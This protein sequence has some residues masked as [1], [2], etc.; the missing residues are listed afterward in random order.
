MYAAAVAVVVYLM[1]MVPA[2]DSTVATSLHGELRLFEPPECADLILN[3]LILISNINLTLYRILPAHC[4]SGTAR[5]VLKAREKEALVRV[6]S[7]P[8]QN[9]TLVM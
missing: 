3:T 8:G 6:Y 1:C 2:P 9:L 4:S 7:P 5:K